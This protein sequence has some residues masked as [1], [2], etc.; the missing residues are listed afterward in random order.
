MNKNIFIVMLICILLI[1]CHREEIFTNFDNNDSPTADS[2]EVENPETNNPTENKWIFVN[3]ASGDDFN[4]GSQTSPLKTIAA[5]I[6]RA[7][8]SSKNSIAVCAGTYDENQLTLSDDISLY[9][10]YE[11]STWTKTSSYGYPTFDKT[12]ETIIRPSGYSPSAIETLKIQGAIIDRS[13]VIDGFTIEGAA[14]QSDGACGIYIT[15]GALPTISNCI[16]NGGSSNAS[17]INTNAGVGIVVDDGSPEI[18]KNIINGGSG[19]STQANF[20]NIGIHVKNAA[21]PYIH[22]NNITGGSGTNNNSTTSSYGAVGI[23]WLS[24]GSAKEG[25]NPIEYN[26]IF[27]GT[28]TV[29]SGTQQAEVQIGVKIANPSFLDILHND[30]NAGNGITVSTDYPRNSVGIWIDIPNSGTIKIYA[31]KIYGGDL[32][33]GKCHLKAILLRHSGTVTIA[34]NMLYGGDSDYNMT[35]INHDCGCIWIEANA[36]SCVTKIYYNTAFLGRGQSASAGATIAFFAL[37]SSAHGS[38]YIENNLLFSDNIINNW[39]LVGGQLYF[40]SFRNNVLTYGGS[41]GNR[42]YSTWYSGGD[43]GL[44]QWGTYAT[45]AEVESCVSSHGGLASGNFIVGNTGT[46]IATTIIAQKI[47]TS[48]DLGTHGYTEF[49]NN[50]WQLV[51]KSDGGNSSI[52]EGARDLGVDQPTDDFYGNPRTPPF[53]IGAHEQDL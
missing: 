32:T 3:Q 24:S 40:T 47:F 20:V 8:M 11:C 22:H 30:I 19:S 6:V 17:A 25:V 2:P 5:A 45:V 31:N 26:T 10:S 15:G 42:I 12:N 51:K 46:P 18:C 13:V 36:S 28:P 29:N 50:Q 37:N 52:T 35:G 49:T 33:S 4:E 16:I 27:G 34:N 9:G 14:G 41:G 21:S 1:T 44:P 7:S 43:C 23:L 53:S 39:P 48:W 38:Y